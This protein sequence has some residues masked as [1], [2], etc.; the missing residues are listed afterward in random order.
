MKERDLQKNALFAVLLV[1]FAFYAVVL[2]CRTAFR[3][4]SANSAV[5]KI[6]DIALLFASTFTLVTVGR[7]K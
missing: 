3:T 2:D 4:P 7:W 5:C 1:P 6:H